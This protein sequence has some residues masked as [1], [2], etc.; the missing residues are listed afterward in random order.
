M[1]R[2]ASARDRRVVNRETAETVGKVKRVLIEPASARAVALELSGA[3]TE[4]SIVAWSDLAGFGPDAVV[5][6]SGQVLRG[7]RDALEEDFVAGRSE[8]LGKRVL[9]DAGE[10][11]GELKDVDL[12][13]PSGEVRAFEL[14]RGDTIR[15]GRMVAVGP[16]AVIIPANGGSNR[17]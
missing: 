13:D 7:P 10:L 11:L 6:P 8:I 15:V 9:T 14:D 1:I 16:Y 2:L 12:E 5:V 3:R 17:R 4:Q